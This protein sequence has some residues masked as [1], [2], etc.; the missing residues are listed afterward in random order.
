MAEDFIPDDVR[1][2]I[3]RYIESIAHL[4]ALLLLRRSPDHAWT[5][6]ATSARLYIS[7][8]EAASV[9]G[10]LCA[11]GLVTFDGKIYSVDVANNLSETIGRVAEAYTQHLIPV[12]NMIHARPRRLREFSDAFKLRKDSQ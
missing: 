9:L 12:T 8:A 4:E 6:A 10:K 3:L 11:D 7:E 5:A 1:A 2:F